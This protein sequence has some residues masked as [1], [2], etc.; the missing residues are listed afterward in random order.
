MA[1]DPN[2]PMQDRI[3]DIGPPHYEQYFPPV[4]KENYGKWKYHEILEPGVLV[5]VSETGA[6]VYTVRVGGCR[7]MS[8]DIIREICDLADKHCDGYMRWTTRNNVEFMVDDKAKLQPL[9]DDLKGRKFDGGSNKF[10]IGGT[11]A[12]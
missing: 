3:T 12:G 10:P 1:F 2:N 8:V 6:E 5:H 11:G 7:L 9:I 4:I